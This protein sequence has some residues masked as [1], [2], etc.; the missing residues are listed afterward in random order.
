MRLK[1]KCTKQKSQQVGYSRAL[2]TLKTL[3]RLS[4]SLV[5]YRPRPFQITCYIYSLVFVIPKTTAEQAL[6][7]FFLAFRYFFYGAK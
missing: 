5:S 4:F 1:V 6:S 7:V 3:D 2:L